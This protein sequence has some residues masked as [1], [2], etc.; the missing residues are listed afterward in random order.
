MST[1]NLVSTVKFENSNGHEA[2]YDI[3]F[4]QASSVYHAEIFHIARVNS[5]G[6]NGHTIYVWHRIPTTYQRI[7]GNT[8]ED[9]VDSCRNNF[10]GK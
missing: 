3:Y 9:I 5:Q 6:P 7:P 4:D 2:K 8:I 1:F 10:L